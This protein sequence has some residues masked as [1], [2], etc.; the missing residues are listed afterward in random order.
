[1]TDRTKGNLCLLLTAVLWGTGFISQKIG[2]DYLPPLSF[3]SIRQ[4][5]AFVVLAPLA[6]S[7]LGKSG[8]LSAKQN[9]RSQLRRKKF[10]LLLAGFICGFCLFAGSAT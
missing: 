2:L 4:L 6:L 8:Y 5:M 7:G 9:L 10:R 3:N 1:M